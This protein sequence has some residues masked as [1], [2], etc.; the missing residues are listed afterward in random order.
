MLEEHYRSL[1]SK[2]EPSQELINNTKSRMYAELNKKA[3]KVSAKSTRYAAIIAVSFA[4]VLLIS[5]TI[6]QLTN[7]TRDNSIQLIR[8]TDGVSVYYIDKPPTIE[9]STIGRP[10]MSEEELING[11]LVFKGNIKDIQYVHVDFEKSSTYLA[12]F[13]I[14]VD[15]VYQ[16]ELR[17]RETIKVMSQRTY[18]G[19]EET[20]KIAM[21]EILSQAKAGMNGIFIIR[22]ID[23]E[24]YIEEGTERLY[25]QDLSPYTFQLAGEC[26]AFLEGSEE[27]I[28][29]KSFKSLSEDAT[30]EQVEQYIISML[31]R[32]TEGQ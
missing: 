7:N 30:F 9:I 32:I 6:S 28:Y 14:K 22:S 18:T 3:S 16:G 17:Q 11:E 23:E 25:L 19:V 15:T 2:I 21:D 29:D 12:I 4:L 27:V 8:S 1:Y 20:G 24:S 31:Q 13:T 26:S 5:L 10:Q